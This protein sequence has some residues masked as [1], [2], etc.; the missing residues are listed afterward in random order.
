MTVTSRTA[1]WPKRQ[2]LFPA[3]N[4]LD[5]KRPTT[6]AV[7]VFSWTTNQVET[8]MP[9]HFVSSDYVERIWHD[10]PSRVSHRCNFVDPRNIAIEEDGGV[11]ALITC[12]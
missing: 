10:V 8:S 7:P 9:E 3:K 1:L 4:V 5:A 2:Y 6:E 11:R 12:S